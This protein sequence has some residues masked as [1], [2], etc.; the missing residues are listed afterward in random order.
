MKTKKLT[1]K[2]LDEHNAVMLTCID[3]ALRV[4]N[5]NLNDP[6]AQAFFDATINWFGLQSTLNLRKIKNR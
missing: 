6:K 5:E 4:R 3:T 2:Q 1:Q